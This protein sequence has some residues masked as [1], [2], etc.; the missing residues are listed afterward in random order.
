MANLYE[1]THNRKHAKDKPHKRGK[2][3]YTS[4]D[5]SIIKHDGA[6]HNSEIKI[7][8][9]EKKGVYQIYECGCGN[10]GCFL[11]IERD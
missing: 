5:M 2:R 11:H 10:E 7:K 4:V 8:E 6:V 3:F 1:I 9:I